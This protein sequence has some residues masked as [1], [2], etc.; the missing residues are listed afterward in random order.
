MYHAPMPTTNPDLPFD[1]AEQSS[2][3]EAIELKLM[4]LE[5]TVQTLD[6]IVIKQD[7][8]IER[9]NRR[10]DQLQSRLEDRATGGESQPG[11]TPADEKPPH[12]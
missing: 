12:Y 7:Q 11:P 3:L 2:R 9:L 4:D 6:D 5:H 1:A 8:T 10:I